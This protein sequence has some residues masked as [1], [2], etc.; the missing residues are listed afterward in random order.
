M[1]QRGSSANIAL[2]SNCLKRMVAMGQWR[3]CEIGEL[4]RHNCLNLLIC[5][6]RGGEQG[7]R[8]QLVDGVCGRNHCIGLLVNF[9]QGQVSCSTYTFHVGF[10]RLVEKFVK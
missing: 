10:T 2:L 8:G 9:L 4:D 6:W 3:H 1:P 5:G 7:D